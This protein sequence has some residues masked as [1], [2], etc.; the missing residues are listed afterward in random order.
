MPIKGGVVESG[1]FRRRV[2]TTNLIC[3]EGRRLET[4][5]ER[6][7]CRN[8]ARMADMPAD[9]GPIYATEAQRQSSFLARLVDNNPFHLY[10]NQAESPART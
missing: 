5:T 6:P 8:C 10:V 3:P 1:E 7:D 2:F 9:E 4:S